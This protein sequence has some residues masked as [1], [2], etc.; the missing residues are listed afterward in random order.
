MLAHSQNAT[1][2]NNP[3]D[4]HLYLHCCENLK[5]YKLEHLCSL[6]FPVNVTKKQSLPPLVA[7]VMD[8]SHKHLSSRRVDMQLA[9]GAD[10]EYTIM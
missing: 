5:S 9:H 7:A 4:H 1:M 3:E 6:G 10:V 2:H 8:P